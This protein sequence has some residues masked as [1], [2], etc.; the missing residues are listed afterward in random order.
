KHIE[1]LVNE[2]EGRLLGFIRKR[3]DQE[4]DVRDIA[5]DV[6][7]QLTVGFNDI[8]SLASVT[9]WLFTT[10]R[11][12]ITDFYRKKKPERLSQKVILQDGEDGPLMLE[13]I[14]PSLTP[15]PEE[16]Y[17]REVVWETIEACLDR[18]PP[19]QREVFVLNEFEDLSFKEIS[20]RTGEGINTLLSRKRY[21]VTYLREQLK[22]LYQEITGQ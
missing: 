22:E 17:M 15:G 2:E 12:R 8:R 20:E 7:Y 18:L 4:E 21:A 1:K 19:L 13:D 16:E 3:V 11:N 6:Y 14:L 10:A 5:Q 9:S